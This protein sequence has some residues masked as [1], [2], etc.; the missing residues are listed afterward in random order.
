MLFKKINIT[1]LK[2]LKDRKFKIFGHGFLLFIIGILTIEMTYNNG[3]KYCIYEYSLL[4]EWIVYFCAITSVIY[5]N[6]EVLVPQFLL[7]GR[8][9]RYVCII[10]LCVIGT[11]VAIITAQNLFFDLSPNSNTKTVLLNIL[12][13]IISISL[14]IVSTS[15]FSLF[16]GWQENS[17]RINEL[18]TATIETELKQ[19]KS[20]INPHFLFNTINNANIKVEKDQDIAYCIITKLEDLLR[21]QLTN[22]SNDKIEL[23]SDISFLIDYLEL[24]KT[25]RNSFFYKIIADESIYNLVVFPLLFIPFV[26]NAVKHSLT[27]K[28]KSTITIEFLKENDRLHFCCENSKPLAPIK[29]KSGGLGLK[30][31]KRRLDLLYGDTYSLDIAESD[32]KYIINLYLKI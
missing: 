12:G 5:L 4:Y 7:K 30:N 3:G 28:G 6:L 31:I 23:K 27:T 19:L 25:R 10:G 13:N 9:T 11:L 16:R 2:L 14:V 1:I 24:E 20:Q 18:E 15:I 17:Q 21:Y 8:L 22:T 26:E 32:E 29:Q